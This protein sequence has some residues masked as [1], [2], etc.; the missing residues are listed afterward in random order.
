MEAGLRDH[1]PDPR[2]ID[3]NV[4]RAHITFTRY[5]LLSRLADESP[6]HGA[7]WLQFWDDV[8]NASAPRW[9]RRPVDYSLGFV[10]RSVDNDRRNTPAN[11]TKITSLIFDLVKRC[12]T[13]DGC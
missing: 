4:C 8:A 6:F 9:V 13:S 12:D 1:G 3:P 11:P 7:V 10:K 2:C 5:S